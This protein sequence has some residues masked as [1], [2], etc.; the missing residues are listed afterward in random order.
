MHG[1][2]TTQ[3]YNHA[4]VEERNA[5]LAVG[6]GIYR[7]QYYWE[8]KYWYVPI[9]FA[10]PVQTKLRRGFEMWMIGLSNFQSSDGSCTPVMPFRRFLSKMLPKGVSTKWRGEW[11]PIFELMMMAPDLPAESRNANSFTTETISDT[12]SICLSFL[13]TEV[14]YIFKK[15]QFETHMNWSVGTWSKMVRPSMIK[16]HGNESDIKNLQKRKSNDEKS[17]DDGS[18]KRRSEATLQTFFSRRRS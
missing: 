18:R 2:T 15:K 10:F 6:N 1:G 14:S 4:P 17:G 5:T 7:Q 12:Y 9:N 8:G 3:Q 16:E 11:K 13:Q